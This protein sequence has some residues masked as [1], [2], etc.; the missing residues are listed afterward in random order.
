MKLSTLL[1]GIETAGFC[2]DTEIT[3][4]TCDSRQLKKGDLFICIR[5]QRFD[6]HAH[7]AEVL[8]RGAAAIV[9]EQ[10]LPL[11][12]V[13]RVPDSREAYAKICANFYG[14]PQ[15]E[16][17][18]AAVTGTS[19]KTTITCLIRDILRAAGKKVGLIGTI[20]GEIGDMIIPAR[21][22]T[23]DPLQLYS[24][25]SRMRAAGVKTV[26]MEA[27]SHALDQQRLAGLRFRCAAF[28]GLSHEHLDY[29][30][31]MENYYQAKRRLF[32]QA[33][34]AVINSDDP[35]G[36]RLIEELTIPLTRY[37]LKDP[38]ADY[39]AHSIESGAA[40]SRFMVMAGSR[41]MRAQLS[42]PGSYSVSNALCAAACAAQ[43]GVEPEEAFAA[44]SKSAGVPGRMEVIAVP[45]PFTVI[46]DYAHTPEEI[47]SVLSAVRSFA[48]ARVVTLFGCPGERDRT[49]RPEMARAVARYSDAAI[50]TSDNPRG[51]DP[52]QIIEDALAGFQGAK[53]PVK[54]F[55]DRYD[56]IRWA[57]ENGRERDILMLLGKGHE[58]YQVLEYGT[59]FFDER[60]I[61]RELVEK[62]NQG[63]SI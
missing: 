60:F 25:L 41:L 42:M 20:Q 31:T 33:D 49:K 30:Q 58:D 2:P 23:P 32:S 10:P 14:N 18:L 38:A 17:T 15:R 11:P 16:L 19:G 9:A 21:H 45:L 27:S 37:A 44:L 39:T 5:G 12:G 54:V 61:V 47:R 46:R 48:P 53:M 13:I 6:G 7:A 62:M 50:L 52:M 29:H 4:V 8:E 28:T 22:T 36:R 1:Q 3:K 51:E 59:I 43:L 26:V 24:M 55:A 34:A 63:D 56:A 35:Y 40:G 57:L